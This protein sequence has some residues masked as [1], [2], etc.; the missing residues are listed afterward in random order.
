M[1]RITNAALYDIMTRIESKVDVL[2]G[3]VN[4]HDTNITILQNHNS[5]ARKERDAAAAERKEMQAALHNIQLTIAKS[6]TIGAVVGAGFT[7]A[8]QIIVALAR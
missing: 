5:Q 2:H 6:A 7:A 4:E 1:T 8:A 3:C